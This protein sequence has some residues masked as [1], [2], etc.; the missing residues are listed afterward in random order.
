MGYRQGFSLGLMVN[1]LNRIQTSNGHIVGDGKHQRDSSISLF[2]AACAA[3]NS[4]TYYLVF[5]RLRFPLAAA[6]GCIPGSSLM[7]INGSGPS[8]HLR[9]PISKGGCQRNYVIPGGMLVASRN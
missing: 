5:T 3:S 4:V 6:R 8:L 7:P 1:E 9:V 2:D